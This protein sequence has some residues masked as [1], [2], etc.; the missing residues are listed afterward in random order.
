MKNH[1]KTLIYVFFCY[2]EHVFSNKI[3]FPSFKIGGLEIQ[4]NVNIYSKEGV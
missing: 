4:E 2:Y 1:T 3:S